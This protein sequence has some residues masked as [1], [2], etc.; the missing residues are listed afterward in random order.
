MSTKD[1]AGTTAS[2]TTASGTPASGTGDASP[3]LRVVRGTPDHDE[4]VALVAG[5]AAAVPAIDDDP[6]APAAHWAAPS[7]TRRVLGGRGPDAWR[8]SARWAQR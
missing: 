1:P 6:A 5:L 3:H 2:G 4:L 7:R 8:W